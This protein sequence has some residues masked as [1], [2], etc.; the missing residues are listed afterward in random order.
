MP[1]PM[2]CR[3]V[4]HFPETLGFSPVEVR[5]VVEPVI[6]AIDEYEAL[7]LIDKEGLNQEQCAA[8]MQIARTTVQRIYDTA[9]K[10]LADC[11][12]DGRPLRIEGGDF[13]LCNGKAME[14]GYND[15]YKQQYH[16]QYKT[17]KGELLQVLLFL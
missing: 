10:K 15:C 3:K 12:V 6:L 2:K 8:F 4:C 16:Q 11:I 9:R 17:E 1:R 7:R 13:R 14:C 5:S